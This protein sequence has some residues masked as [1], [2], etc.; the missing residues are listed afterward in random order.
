MTQLK[1]FL[2]QFITR[3]KYLLIGITVGLLIAYAAFYVFTYRTIQVSGVEAEDNA[4]VRQAVKNQSVFLLH[5]Q[6]I[7]TKILSSIPVLKAVQVSIRLP[8]TVSLTVRYKKEFANVITDAGYLIVAE[9]GT[10]LKKVRGKPDHGI[11]VHNN[12][13]IRHLEYQR[14]QRITLRVIQRAL[15]AIQVLSREE[16]VVD[17]VDIDSVDMIACKTR[18]VV[19]MFSQTRDFELQSHEIRQ[20][21]K[22]LRLGDLKIESV[23]LRF[24]KPIVRTRT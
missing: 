5:A 11:A 3:F 19:V 20:I 17:S 23:D 18:T 24:D 21:L 12:F 9:D 4:L 6:A 1:N 10:V 15:Q 7:E 8:D 14:G 13:P 2:L 16:L 22:R